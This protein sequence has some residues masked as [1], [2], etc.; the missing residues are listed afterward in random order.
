MDLNLEEFGFTQIEQIL[1]KTEILKES[2][3]DIELAKEIIGHLVGIMREQESLS[4]SS[5]KVIEL[6]IELVEN[7][8]EQIKVLKEIANIKD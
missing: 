2:L 6:Q 5:N 8:R 7:L 1:V 4:V 3:E